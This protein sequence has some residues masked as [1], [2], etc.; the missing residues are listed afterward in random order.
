[1]ILVAN[2]C[3]HTAGAEIE[4]VE[5]V[6]LTDERRAKLVAFIEG[7]GYI[8]ADAKKRILGQLQKDKVPA[9]VVER[10]ESRMGG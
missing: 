5:M 9:N 4:E 6:E 1:M 7:N 10:I 8:P 2:G 3:S